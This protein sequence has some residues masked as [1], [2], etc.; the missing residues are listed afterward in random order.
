MTGLVHIF[1][2]DGADQ[3]G[4]HAGSLVFTLPPGYRP[5]ATLVF[6]ALKH[7]NAIGGINVGADGHV[8]SCTAH[9]YRDW[10]SLDGIS[11]RC[12]PAGQNGCP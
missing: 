2:P 12:A 5:S 11:F 3:E 8:I 7:D 4:V 6:P 10:L 9:A 1:D